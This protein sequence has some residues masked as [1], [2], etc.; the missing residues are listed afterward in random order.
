MSKGVL[1]IIQVQ[2]NFGIMRI[3]KFTTMLDTHN[4]KK[5]LKYTMTSVFPN[6]QSH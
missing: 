1:K 6:S 4:I 5:L 2:C 3:L